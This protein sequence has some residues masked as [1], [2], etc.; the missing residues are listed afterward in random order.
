MFE[1][2]IS[3][4]AEKQIKQIKKLYQTAILS[5]LEELREDPFAGKPLSKDLTGR[6]SYKISVYR[7]IYKVDQRDK[8]VD[9]IFAGH[10][11]IIYE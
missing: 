3:S 8:V 6:F 1:V 7:I 5:A 10:R 4:K 11:S 9:I 2:R